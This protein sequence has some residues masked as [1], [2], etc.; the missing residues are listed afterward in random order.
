M[1]LKISYQKVLEVD[2]RRPHCS[3]T[4]PPLRAGPDLMIWF[5]RSKNDFDNAASAMRPGETADRFRCNLW[6]K[7]RPFGTALPGLTVLCLAALLAAGNTIA[8][9]GLS[10]R[11]WT[12]DGI[13]REA[14][15]Y[16]TSDAKT[17]AAPVVFIFHGHGGSMQN[18]ARS[19]SIHT[20][21]PEAIVVYMQGLNTPGRLTDRG[22]KAPGWQRSAGDQGNRDLKFFDAVLASLKTDYAVDDRRIY[23]S[24]H[25]NG[26]GFTY[27]LWA[28]RGNRFAAVA[29]S[30]AVSAESVPKLKPKPV[31]HVAG[32][33]DP[34][35]K[36]AWQ[37]QMIRALRRLNQC[38]RGQ[39][40]E[41]EQGCTV[42]PSKIGDSVVTFIHPG[43]HRLPAAAPAIIVK[44]FKEHSQP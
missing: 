30:A 15:I 23:A 27:L 34:L 42:Y 28:E 9:E 3:P 35:V 29:P 32:E 39:P 1:I 40:W 17:R 6:R 25:S 41:A 20:L 21:W 26:G 12:V 11:T 33:Q 8:A 36:F 16:T 44:F 19:F 2:T 31:L 13:V 24:G 37:E 43:N 14:L 7:S 18:A 38:G 22:G 5:A 4:E 10:R